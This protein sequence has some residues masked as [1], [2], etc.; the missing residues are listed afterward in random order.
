MAQAGPI[1]II[2]D[3]PDDMSFCQEV[4]KTIGL[5]NPL[6]CF[7]K[8]HDALHYLR[9]CSV[10][11]FIIFVDVK[12]PRMNGLEFQKQIETNA[13]LKNKS[14]PLI[15]FTGVHDPITIREAYKNVIQ[16][17]FMKPSTMEEMVKLF[18][19]II[20]YWSKCQHPHMQA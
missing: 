17:Y 16:G 11:P 13:E 7:N 5:P 19:E 14:I 15:F 4:F 8:P 12:M 6:E 20:S 2:D 1:V 9:S 10:P 3:D 18:T